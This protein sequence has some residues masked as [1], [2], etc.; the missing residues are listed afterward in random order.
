M[1]CTNLAVTF[2]KVEHVDKQ[3]IAATRKSHAATYAGD[4]QMTP[5]WMTGRCW[6]D[7]KLQWDSRTVR[8]PGPESLQDCS[9]GW[10]PGQRHRQQYRFPGKRDCCALYLTAQLHSPNPACTAD[11][12]HSC[13]QL[14]Y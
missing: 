2:G 7:S 9:Y 6:T 14:A 3:D 8:Q 1:K 5:L 12:T 13:I 4:L 11:C 10:D